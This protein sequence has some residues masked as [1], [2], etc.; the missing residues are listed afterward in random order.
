MPGTV[1]S[2]GGKPDTAVGIVEAK[3][4]TERVGVLDTVSRRESR[5]E[6]LDARLCS[7]LGLTGLSGSVLQGCSRSVGPHLS[8]SRCKGGMV[9]SPGLK[10]SAGISQQE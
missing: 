7:G 9:R 2:T 10:S 1:L 5:E 6:S 3:S 8:C 4:E